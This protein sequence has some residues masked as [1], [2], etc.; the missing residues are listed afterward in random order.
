MAA[1]DGDELM[2]VGWQ[3]VIRSQ[4]PQQRCVVLLETDD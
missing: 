4:R 1:G 3:I 2:S